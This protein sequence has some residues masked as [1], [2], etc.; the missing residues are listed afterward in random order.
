MVTGAKKA[1]KMRVLD[2]F[3][4]IFYPV[5]IQKDESRGVLALLNSGSKVN[6]MTPAYAAQLCLKMQKTNIGAQK[7]DGFLLETYSMVIIVF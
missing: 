5:Q 6:A 1:Q 7:I 2:K 3:I 4:C